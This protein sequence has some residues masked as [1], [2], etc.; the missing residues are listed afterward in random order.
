[1]DLLENSFYTLGATL[2]DDRRT[3]TELSDNR[4]L[5]L[6]PDV[7]SRARADLT[8]PRKRLSC[9]VAW[10]PGLGPKRTN[11]VIS[12]LES[13]LPDIIE[14]D[15][16]TSIAKANL[17]AAGLQRINGTSANDLV[18][19]IL[20]LARA[21]GELDTEKL[22]SIVN[23]ERVVSGFP[24]VSDLSVVD[25][26]I[27]ERR[28]YFKQV[29]KSALN[30]LPPRIRTTAMTEVVDRATNNGNEQGPILIDDLVDAYEVEAQGFLKKEGDNIKELV[31]KLRE[32]ADAGDSDEKLGEIVEKLTKVLK[33]WDLEAQPIQ[34][35]TKSRGLEHAAS[36]EIAGQVRELIIY[37]HN[38]LGKIEIPKQLTSLLQEVFAEVV[39]I[40][41]R[42]SDDARTL[43][44]IAE[45]R[46]KYLENVEKRT[47]EWAK[48]V[49]YEADVGAL[50]KNKLRISPDGIEWKR[51]HWD[52]SSIVAVRWGGVRHSVNGIP[53]GTTYTIAWGDGNRRCSIELRKN[54]IY[55]NFI[56]RLWKAVCIRLMTEFVEGLR[57][58]QKYQFG[59]AVISDSGIELTRPKWFSSN[60]K[61]FCKWSDIVTWN[62]DGAFGIQKKGDNKLSHELS[63]LNE[64]NIHIVEQVIQI[65]FKQTKENPARALKGGLKLSS[66]FD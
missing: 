32:S 54:T 52:L 35:S 61:E 43:Q 50:F 5:L 28:R 58:G 27:K 17:V 36:R 21:F 33:N 20:T 48:E 51:K 56:D 65:F 16:I 55:S 46:E 13:S 26:E 19:W 62:G 15:N 44:D 23:E 59:G 29:C 24:Q 39:T 1:M 18:M 60:E 9:E 3:I 45:D 30:R 57:N 12:L 47:A 25:E 11:E 66:I 6:N 14:I 31:S 38:K 37:L 63:Y 49:T 53:T 41:E 64:D 8:H 10:L 42:T 22:G 7:C 4:S 2:R 34:V 40:A